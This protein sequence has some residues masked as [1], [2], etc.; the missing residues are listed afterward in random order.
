MHEYLHWLPQF[1]SPLLRV[2]NDDE[3]IV[4]SLLFRKLELL[5]FRKDREGSQSDRQILNIVG[6]ILSARGNDGRFE[7]VEA[8][9]GQFVLAAVREF[10]VLQALNLP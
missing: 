5:A 4:V 1:F 6:G 9:R 8:R 10:P 7:F 2:S 3:R